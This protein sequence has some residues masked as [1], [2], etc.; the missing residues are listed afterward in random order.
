MAFFYR[1]NHPNTQILPQTTADNPIDL[2][3]PEPPKP[4]SVN[5][6]VDLVTPEM[7]RPAQS[8]PLSPVSGASTSTP[9]DSTPASVHVDTM[10]SDNVSLY[11]KTYSNGNFLWVM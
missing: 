1:P 5:A 8:R 10:G 7:R 11:L 4:T 9:K 6:P 2:T 3:T